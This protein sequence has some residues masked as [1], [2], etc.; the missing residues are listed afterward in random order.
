MTF[1]LQ[2]SILL[3]DV[4]L[5]MSTS[6]YSKEDSI[7]QISY[8][9]KTQNQG[10]IMSN[11]PSSVSRRHFIKQSLVA[12]AALAA[13]TIIPHSVLGKDA[14]SNRIVM[15][16]IGCGKQS[17][18][19]LRAFIRERGTQVVSLCDVDTLKLNRD[20]K[21]AQD[22]YAENSGGRG[23]GK[24]DR[25][26]ARVPGAEPGGGARISDDAVFGHLRPRPRVSFP[27]LLRPR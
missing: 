24:M 25:F 20:L 21:I 3:F 18:H 9:W 5:L 7:T 8:N 6:V 27:V 26:R 10:V 17:K 1:K 11:R 2:I 19:L 13:P 4:F 16:F 12:G 22:Y 23:N 14:P 15:G